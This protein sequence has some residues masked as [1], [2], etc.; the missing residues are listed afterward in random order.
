M[1][2][3][4]RLWEFDHTDLDS[5]TKTYMPMRLCTVEDFRE[6]DSEVLYTEEALLYGSESLLCMDTELIKLYG[7]HQTRFVRSAQI[8]ITDCTG[9]DCE[10]DPDLI[11]SFKSRFKGKLFA[12]YNQI[13]FQVYDRQPTASFLRTIARLQLRP[14]DSYEI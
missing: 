2:F 4:V 6:V 11:E 1:D 13:D 3:Q 8:E 5:Y 7:N 9:D 10:T 12:V 14:E